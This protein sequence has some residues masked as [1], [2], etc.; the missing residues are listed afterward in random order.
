M[1]MYVQKAYTLLHKKLYKCIPLAKSPLKEK[2]KNRNHSEIYF[3]VLV[4]FIWLSIPNS[5]RHQVQGQ[6]KREP[7]EKLTNCTD[8]SDIPDYAV[9]CL[10][11][12]IRLSEMFSLGRKIPGTEIAYKWLLDMELNK[13]ISIGRLW[14]DNLPKKNPTSP[15][16]INSFSFNIV[17]LYISILGCTL[18]ISGFRSDI[19]LVFGLAGF[20]DKQKFLGRLKG[21]KAII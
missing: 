20:P 7:K 15:A 13:E 12:E 21:W 1:R 9:Y 14:T 18:L 5:G 3:L 8:Y 17:V 16:M 11:S 6:K 10:L 19:N 2:P 4:K